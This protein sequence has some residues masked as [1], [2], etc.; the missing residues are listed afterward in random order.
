MINISHITTTEVVVSTIYYLGVQGRR[1][2]DLD[3]RQ[4]GLLMWAKTL[5][6]VTAPTQFSSGPSAKPTT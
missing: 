6:Q 2:N 4:H 5:G 3:I 1:Q